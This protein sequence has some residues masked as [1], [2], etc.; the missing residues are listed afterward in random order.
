[1]F[2]ARTYCAWP[3]PWPSGPLQVLMRSASLTHRAS[4]PH[5]PQSSLS[6]QSAHAENIPHATP[7]AEQERGIH[8]A[9][10]H[11]S[12]LQGPSSPPCM[13]SC[14]SA[15]QPQPG[16]AVHASQLASLHGALPVLP[17]PTSDQSRAA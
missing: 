8:S 12:A 2:G 15:H 13:H 1:M 11:S 3:H 9:A 4:A 10:E 6:V 7:L 17:A 14:R 5:Q 16:V